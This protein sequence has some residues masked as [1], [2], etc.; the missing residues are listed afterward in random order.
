MAGDPSRGVFDPPVGRK[1]SIII[2]KRRI[3][4]EKEDVRIITS[5]STRSSTEMFQIDPRSGSL[6][7]A[8]P[9]YQFTD[10]ASA[11][12][13]LYRQGYKEVAR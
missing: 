13:S 9:V 7:C 2:L 1:T 8:T 5:L 4:E 11:V 10:E 3:S 6:Q 12:E